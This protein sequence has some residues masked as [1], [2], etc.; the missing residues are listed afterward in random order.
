MSYLLP[1]RIG[2]IIFRDERGMTEEQA[3]PGRK[4]YRKIFNAN[5]NR[6]RKEIGE[7]PGC[8]IR[9]EIYERYRKEGGHEGYSEFLSKR[10]PARKSRDRVTDINFLML[11]YNRLTD[12]KELPVGGALF[13]AVQIIDRVAVNIDYRTYC[14]VITRPDGLGMGLLRWLLDH[15]HDARADDG[16]IVSMRLTVLDFPV[17]DARNRWRSNLPHTQKYVEELGDYIEWGKT[18]EY[19]YPIRARK[20]ARM[21]GP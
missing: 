20:P 12:G 19:R 11:A 14:T 4:R 1:I 6:M 7:D 17:N 5:H 3:A 10:E 18:T 16:T 9:D 21:T 2:S 15:R 8:G 13:H